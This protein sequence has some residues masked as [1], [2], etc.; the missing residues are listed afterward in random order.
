[1]KAI[2][3]LLFLATFTYAAPPGLTTANMTAVIVEEIA[4]LAKNDKAFVCSRSCL[5]GAVNNYLILQ[6]TPNN[7][8]SK[9]DLEKLFEQQ[10][11]AYKN[12]KT[13]V[14]S[15]PD[16][17][18]KSFLEELA[19]PYEFN[20]VENYE[21]SKSNY[22]KTTQIL[23]ENVLPCAKQC[24]R[25]LTTP[26]SLLEFVSEYSRLT[27]KDAKKLCQFSECSVECLA[28]RMEE[29]KLPEMAFN[30]MEYTKAQMRAITAFFLRQGGFTKEVLPAE[31]Q[32]YYENPEM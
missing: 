17:D 15:C 31:C 26:S 3:S 20:C 4:K 9:Q 11:N 14:D 18:L 1:M 2:F 25:N 29:A 22:E 10:C 21:E 7:P 23:V 27:T 16:G 8:A 32:W 19:E 30:F 13:C 12:G 24:G 5:A 6:S 28:D